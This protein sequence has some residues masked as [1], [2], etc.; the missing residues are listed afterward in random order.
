MSKNDYEGE[1]M[2]ECMAISAAC[3]DVNARILE[4]ATMHLDA[5]HKAA[6]QKGRAAE[7]LCGSA[8]ARPTL[9]KHA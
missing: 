7:T 6:C 8:D 2:H 1:V 3:T 9:V 5:R 4:S